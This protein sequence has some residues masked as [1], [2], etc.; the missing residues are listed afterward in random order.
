MTKEELMALQ[1][2]VL[3]VVKKLRSNEEEAQRAEEHLAIL[4]YG[5]DR[6]DDGMRKLA[7]EIDELKL[8]TQELLVIFHRTE[9]DVSRSLTRV[10]LRGKEG[11]DD[12]SRA[13]S[14]A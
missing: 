14:G 5:R 8:T 11:E 10:K 4:K 12:A 9:Q 1:Q 2:R 3:A 7:G 6:L 13:G